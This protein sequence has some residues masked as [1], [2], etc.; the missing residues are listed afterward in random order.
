[1]FLFLF[2]FGDFIQ[3]CTNFILE[4]IHFRGPTPIS[5]NNLTFFQRIT[6]YNVTWETQEYRIDSLPC[7][8]IDQDNPYE[9]LINQNSSYIYKLGTLMVKLDIFEFDEILLEL[10]FPKDPFRLTTWVRCMDSESKELFLEIVPLVFLFC[11][12]LILMFI[13]FKRR[14][15]REG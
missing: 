11:E 7:S 3:V 6:T 5:V 10:D 14:Q 12:I 9:F 2:F 15:K 8:P 4:D 1:L 13:F